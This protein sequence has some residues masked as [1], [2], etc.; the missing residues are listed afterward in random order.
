MQSPLPVGTRIS[1][2]SHLGTVRFIGEV[3]G[4][5]GIWLGIEWDDPRRGKHSG[6]KDGKEYFSCKYELLRFEG[7][8]AKLNFFWL[9]YPIQ[10]LSFAPVHL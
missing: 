8:L 6:S 1:Y 9:G 2:L 10:G 3:E 4:T 5:R 7:F